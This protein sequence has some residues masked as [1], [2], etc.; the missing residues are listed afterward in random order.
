MRYPQFL[1]EN[2][3]IGFVAPSFGCANEP[4]I[5]AFKNAQKKLSQKVHMLIL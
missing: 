2:G 4:Y 5:R 1:K 3:I